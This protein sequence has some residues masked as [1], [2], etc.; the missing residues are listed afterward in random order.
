[1]SKEVLNAYI[2][3][4]KYIQ[5]NNMTE[6]KKDQATSGLL[7]R[8]EKPKSKEENKDIDLIA[9]YV[10]MIAKKRQ[11]LRNVRSR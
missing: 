1:M 9:K 7:S 10:L 6:P 3:I 4:T 11:E 8:N 2:N 5:K